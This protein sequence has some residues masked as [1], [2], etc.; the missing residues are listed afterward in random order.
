MLITQRSQ[1]Q[2][3]PRPPRPE[4]LLRHEKSLLHVTGSAG[5]RNPHAVMYS[6]DRVRSGGLELA[7]HRLEGGLVRAGERV[8][9][10]RVEQRREQRGAVTG[11]RRQV[12]A[13]DG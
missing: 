4:A 1:V 9:L 10:R 11:N 8:G 7:Q 3:L 2:V 6:L 12:G 13:E 5:R